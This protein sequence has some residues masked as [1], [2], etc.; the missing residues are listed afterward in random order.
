LRAVDDLMQKV[1]KLHEEKQTI[2]FSFSS[3]HIVQFAVVVV[4]VIKKE[5][6][7]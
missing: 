7:S 2:I 1:E 5:H 3:L 4:A 6:L